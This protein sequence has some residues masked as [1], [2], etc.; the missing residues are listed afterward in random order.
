MSL[1]LSIEIVTYDVFYTKRNI[2]KWKQVVHVQLLSKTQTK[3]TDLPQT[4]RDTPLWLW[5]NIYNFK[6][7]GLFLEALNNQ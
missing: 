6:P 4:F 2:F 7:S 3:S 1:S 5:T